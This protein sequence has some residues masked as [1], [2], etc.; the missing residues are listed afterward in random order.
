[1]PK[2][3]QIIMNRERDRD[4]EKQRDIT[5]SNHYWFQISTDI[6]NYLEAIIDYQSTYNFI[7]FNTS[8]KYYSNISRLLGRLF[9][10]R[11]QPLDKPSG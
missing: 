4:R 5:Y 10:W 11:T 3:S 6:L 8:S 7:A 9:Q 1:M 2:Y